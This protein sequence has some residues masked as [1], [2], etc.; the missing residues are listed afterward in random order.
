MLMRL[1][2]TRP[3][4]ASGEAKQRSVHQPRMPTRLLV[5]PL[6]PTSG[7][8]RQRNGPL[9]LLLAKTQMRLLDT[10]PPLLGDASSARK[11]MV[12]DNVS[13]RSAASAGKAREYS[14]NMPT[15]R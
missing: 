4:L 8:A 2:V 14:M 7:E 6:P 10:P 3:L 12:Y 1:L 5:T 11:L 13:S 15:R 9:S